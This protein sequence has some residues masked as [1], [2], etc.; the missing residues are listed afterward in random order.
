MS[1]QTIK[2]ILRTSV[3]GVALIS[4]TLP[5]GVAQTTVAPASGEKSITIYGSEFFA[6]KNPQTA[7]DMVNLLPGFIFSAGDPT[8]RGYAAA[9]GNV[10]I[11]GERVADKQFSLD[12]VLQRIPSDQVDHIEV[13]QGA[14]E[15]VEMLGQTIVANV[16][17]KRLA[18]NKVVVT[19][20]NGS[21]TDGRQ[22]PGGTLELTK[23][24]TGGRSLSS[25]VS[26]LKYIEL[27]EGDGPDV[28]RNPHG[29][30]INRTSVASDAGGLTGFAYGTLSLPAWKG[31]ASINGSVSRTDY[32]YNET[33]SATF[34][35]VSSS[36]LSEHLGGPL[37]GQIQNELGAHF[38]RHLGERW[39]SESVVLADYMSQTY[40][41]LLLGPGLDE[42]FFEH[43]HVGETLARS[44]LRCTATGH[45]TA[46]FSGEGTYNWLHT[47]STFSYNSIPISLPNAIAS[48]SE[49]R[50]QFSGNLI[51]SPRKSVELELGSLIENSSINS[52]ADV[53]RSKGLT[54]I[55]PRAVLRL[56]PNS[57]NQFR[58]RIER[59]VGQLNFADFVAS[60]SLNT[61]SI[62]SGNTD[63]VPQQD[64]VFEGMYER[65]FWSD[66]DLMLTYQHFVLGDVYDRVAVSSP[67]A[68]SV[69]FDAAGNI[70]NGSED[71]L[72]L[73]VTIPLDHLRMKT[74][75]LKIAAVRQ[76][77]QATDPTT[78][79]T[80]QISGVEPFEYTADFH[81]DLPR[82]HS[83]WGWSFLTPCAKITTVTPKGCTQ[84]QYRFNEIDAYRAT[85]T[86]NLFG[87]FRFNKGLLLH[88]EGDNLLQQHYDR[89]IS[90]YA[91]PRD[92]FPLTNADGRKLTSV[93]SLL[94]SVRKEF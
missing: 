43:E 6:D 24:W 1:L 29:A 17:R 71:T 55:K 12:T 30:T 47:G 37:G 22:T 60:S 4:T 91:G 13:I 87:E 72:R 82:W 93:S 67:S 26:A 92:S 59:E 66:G 14:K 54:Y 38:S 21:F 76:W 10:L 23:H 25:A 63:I 20:E 28:N 77:S 35:S 68:P 75:Q 51:W 85:P 88:V 16:V 36:T 89:V 53:S 70:G 19:L 50:E 11:D 34:P 57:A 58:M 56:L 46:E 86:I 7:F 8:L 74:A 90:Y 61:G 9:A 40:S 64:W 78:H 33:D 94:V 39:T 18:S 45:L 44:N 5:A 62:H 41:S 2:A 27:A 80:R 3:A 73:G 52:Q 49:L 69:F 32:E 81:Q 79:S 31:V 65:H 83:N 48:V 84:T 15:G 42:Q